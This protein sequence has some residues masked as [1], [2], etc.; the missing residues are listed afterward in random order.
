MSSFDCDVFAVCE[1][2]LRNKDKPSIKGYTWIGN[3]RKQIHKKAKR[4]S[5]G[6][7]FFIKDN[8]VKSSNVSVVDD[9]SD[10]ILWIKL[11]TGQDRF[12]FLCVCYLP[13]H[14]SS[15][16]VESDVFLHKLLESVYTYQTQGQVC[17]VGDF[18]ARIGISSDYIEG[19]DQ[20]PP[21][22]PIDEGYNHHGQAL[23]DFL[24]ETNTCVLNGR[25]GSDNFTHVSHRGRS[26]VDYVIVP[27][28]QLA[29]YSDFKVSLMSET[30]DT[31]NIKG[32]SSV[33]DH[34]VLSFV[35]QTHG[36]TESPSNDPVT[37]SSKRYVL[38][39][40]PSDFL[41]DS[42]SVD[43]IKSTINRIEHDLH[44]LEDVDSA[45][46]D[47]KNLISSELDKRVKK[48]HTGNKPRGNNR[49]KTLY[50]PYWND[51]LQSQLTI[52]QDC[53]RKWLSFKGSATRR[54]VLKNDY[55]EQRKVFDRLNRKFKRQYQIRE[56]NRLHNLLLGK[57]TKDLWRDIGKLGM[58]NDRK[59]FIPMETTD[60]DGNI[61]RDHNKVLDCWKSKYEKLYNCDPDSVDC[62]DYEHLQFIQ[63]KLNHNDVSRPE[64]ID[65][66]ALN[67]PITRD[68]VIKAVLRS[69]IGKSPG[70]DNIPVDVLRNDTCVEILLKIFTFCFNK[71]VIP[72]AWANGI[73]NPIPKS[74]TQ[75]LTD[76]LSYRGISL[77]S[78]P[79]KIYSDILG[80]RLNSWLEHNE[81]IADEQNGFRKKRSCLDHLHSLYSV[82]N[83][84]KLY[85]LST[86]V[87]FVDAKKA[88]DTVN[89][90][91]LW[92]KLMSI[93]ISG[94]FL[95]A[96][97]S[98]YKDIKCAVRINNYVTDW[99]NVKNGV[100]QGCNISPT[101][102]SI[103]INDL[104]TE[105]NNL[106]CGVP[107][108][109]LL[110]SI[111]LYADD[112]A[113]LAP[114]ES[115]LQKMLH[116]LHNWCK[117][118]RLQVN[119]E[120]TKIIHFRNKSIPIS[121]FCF[122]CGDLRIEIATK[123]KYLGLWFTEFLDM[124]MA[125]RELAKSASRALG[126]LY[127]KFK[128]AG[129]MS[130]AVFKNLYE[131]LVEPV[132]FYGAGIWGINKYNFTQLVQNKACRYF[133]GSGKNA[134][135]VATRGDLGWSSCDVK[136]KVEVCR[137]WLRLRETNHDR[138]VFKI[139]LWSKEKRKSWECRVMKLLNQRSLYDYFINISNVKL[140]LDTAR[141]VFMEEDVNDW[142]RRLW[143]DKGHVNGNKLRT[144]RTY[145]NDLVSE[146]YVNN[147]MHFYHRQVLAKFRCGNLK[148]KVE[149][150][151]YSR[152]VV[153]LQD[154]LCTLCSANSIEDE[155]HFLTSCE[156]YSDIRSNLYSSALKFNSSF[157][158]MDDSCKFQFL[159]TNPCI[160]NTLAASLYYMY[161][162]RLCFNFS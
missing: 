102:F 143:D 43:L 28:E 81:I 116:T 27:H 64:N 74:D 18:N 83:N 85:K 53:E 127:T 47:F 40:L 95:E 82:I 96:V 24:V 39:S 2:F 26:V 110:I 33:S 151:R 155:I 3:N 145:K 54:K 93:G 21:R 147:I 136:Q 69:K 161:R 87:C 104:S 125:A 130:H 160:Q 94:L 37:S 13:P 120:K 97:K 135:N 131:S 154:R 108:G 56:K 62:F 119:V 31:F 129:G 35:L 106:K 68:E 88:F 59:S 8:I 30:V 44:D 132:L 51:T 52:A 148:L 14:H 162:R 86:F 41:Q 101:L 114:D 126:A 46:T 25:L 45:Y 76:P 9:N 157:L 20:V 128:F 16:P 36:L 58:A 71:S 98:L 105:I 7:G 122:K 38:S 140:C 48:V 60:V 19:V 49:R 142:Y 107:F 91:C 137:L 73:I 29:T 55:C 12:L 17:I 65:T 5:G 80:Q 34:S 78:V 32:Y 117:K 115:S 113:L 100:K 109:D 99:F 10:D 121:N 57:N 134:S 139:H 159:M 111:L 50:K 66:S 77:L 158:D 6:V 22:N 23:L 118:W 11:S 112:I 124:E 152:P 123:Y 153:P 92:F 75:N 90:D 133:L 156:F 15:R 63:G 89:R 42:S 144:Y 4:G 84:R 67:S 138:L 70:F 103:Y 150:G 1:T 141:R 149:T 61:V 146:P 72:S 79:S